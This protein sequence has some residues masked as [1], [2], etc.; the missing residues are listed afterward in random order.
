MAMNIDWMTIHCHYKQDKV[1]PRVDIK[2]KGRVIFEIYQDGG[3]ITIWMDEADFIDFK[4]QLHYGYENAKI[5][6]R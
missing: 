6:S 4:N 2:E 1:T 3:R 5:N